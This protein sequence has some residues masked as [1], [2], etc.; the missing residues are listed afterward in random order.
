M[1]FCGAVRS[2]TDNTEAQ[3][4]V[5]VV[6]V[7]VIAATTV[8]A[9]VAVVRVDISTPQVLLKTYPL[10]YIRLRLSEILAFI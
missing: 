4:I 2:G 7:V 6:V 9:V 1:D 3:V 10:K 8:I 5:L